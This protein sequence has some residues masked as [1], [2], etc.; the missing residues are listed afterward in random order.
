MGMTPTVSDTGVRL[1]P[2]E[3]WLEFEAPPPQALAA[4]AATTTNVSSERDFICLPPQCGRPPAP[5]P[6]LAAVQ[7][8][9][10]E[11]G[12]TRSASLR[13]PLGKRKE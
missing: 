2:G 9:L 13:E 5:S 8:Q 7:G 1:P 4:T 11:P 12:R 3:G 10:M 6:I